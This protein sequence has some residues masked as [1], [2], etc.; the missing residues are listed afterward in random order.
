MTSSTERSGGAVVYARDLLQ[1]PTLNAFPRMTFRLL[2]QVGLVL[3][4]FLERPLF[5]CPF[6]SIYVVKLCFS[7][8]NTWEVN[9][10][11]V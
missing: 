6:P 3:H 9:C 2:L 4:L 5:Y 11:A 10:C 7:P 8:V 1:G